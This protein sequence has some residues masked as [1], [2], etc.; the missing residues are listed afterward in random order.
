MLK[1]LFEQRAKVLLQLGLTRVGTLIAGYLVSL[2]ADASLV[3]QTL[4]AVAGLAA[5][6]FDV[7][8]T[9]LWPKEAR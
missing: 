5:V 9:K 8:V 4:L 6:G 2:G 7:L 1:S 3:D